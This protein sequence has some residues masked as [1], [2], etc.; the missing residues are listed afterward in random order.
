MFDVD[1]SNYNNPNRKTF[2]SMKPHGVFSLA[3]GQHILDLGCGPGFDVFLAGEK[4]NSTGWVIGVDSCTN[5]LFQAQENIARYTRRTGLN[6]V[7]FRLGET[8]NLPVADASIDVV[9]ANSISGHLTDS[10]LAWREIFRV[11]KPGGKALVTQI[12]LVSPL[13]EDMREP[14]FAL[15]ACAANARLPEEITV[16]IEEAGFSS[17]LLTP[18]PEHLRHLHDWNDP[19]FIDLVR[20]LPDDREIADFV[21]SLNINAYK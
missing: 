4:V 16:T 6:N 3:E 14:V 11:L 10:A 18:Q 17:V 13:P 15:I 7:E 9:L 1:L 2:P 20:A 5:T 8:E 12:A 21:V 19:L